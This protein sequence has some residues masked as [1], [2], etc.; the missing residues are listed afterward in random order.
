MLGGI[1]LAPLMTQIKVDLKSFASDMDKAAALGVAKSKEISKSMADVMAIT[2]GA[3]KVGKSLTKHITLPLLGIGVA[4]GK[5]Y[6]DMEDA[7]SGVKK[8]VEG[9]PEQL[10]EVKDR[11]DNMANTDLAVPRKELYGIAES[12]GQLGVERENITGFT[13]SIAKI[14]RV[15]NLSYEEGSASLA[16][17]ANI[18][19]MPLEKI[20][21]LG[22]TIVHLD[23][24]L[25]TSA[26]E[27]V[28]MGM[29]LAAAGKQAGM[30]EADVM[31]LAGALSSVGLEAEAGGSAF[32]RVVLDMNTQVQSGGEKLEKYAQ[33]AGMTGKEFQKAFKE[34]AAAAITEFLL[35]L[36]RIKDEGGNV[37]GVIE[38][39]GFKELR[40]RD[41]LLRATE[42]GDL[43]A[44]SIGQANEAWKE[45]T[46]LNEV[47][48]ERTDNVRA[49]IDLLRNK[50]SIM[51]ENIGSIF[52]PHVSN[53]IDKIGVWVDK[54]NALDEGIQANIL[55]LAGL[56]MAIGPVI[57]LV[58]GAILAFGK[59]KG[60]LSA[61][62]FALDAAGLSI[63]GLSLPIM[64][65]IAIMALFAVAVA[66]NFGGIRD[67]ITSIMHSIASIIS[68]VLGIIK[69][70]WNSNFLG[71]KTITKT[72]FDSIKT[73]FSTVLAVIANIF[74]IFASA[75][76]RDWKGV[77]EGVKG[78]FSSIWK[79]IQRLM[80]NFLNILIMILVGAGSRFLSAA[81]TAF[82]AIWNGFK[83]VWNSIKSW[84]S[85]VVNDPVGTLKGI[86]TA[87]FNAGK[88]VFTSMWDG[89]KSIWSSITGWV[90]EK[91]EWLKDKVS[92]WKKESG[93]MKTNGSHYTGLSYVPFD[94]YIAKLHK[95]ER[96]LTAEENKSYMQGKSNSSNVNVTNNFYGK[97]ESPYEVS[98]ATKKSMR[99]LQFS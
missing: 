66:T 64:G 63:T 75:F 67:N 72:I 69:K 31:G 62:K 37:T 28:N 6:I 13:E 59:F 97:V 56:V 25:A 84:F 87:M 29:R 42:A 2:K 78:I 73:I 95:G 36:G 30:T 3:K 90:S 55:K 8:T 85:R 4:S 79:G 94:G 88:D 50:L 41:A 71:I 17:F 70:M 77:W 51:H 54:F 76:K 96:V 99:D 11:L 46:A 15:T 93:N 38:D 1:K 92:F 68:S 53:V 21:L 34:D 91:V 48:A 65:A 83:N 12:A 33:I 18:M 43:F 61:A 7:F 57:S 45:G 82:T 89:M 32:S 24:E 49:K 9:T 16:K 47:Y 98:K 40:T 86:G 80:G 23:G 26:D 60:T 52:I 74:K 39:L 58:S 19:N 10:Q 81:R 5:V 20:D 35:G 27:I 44:D 22:S 14:G